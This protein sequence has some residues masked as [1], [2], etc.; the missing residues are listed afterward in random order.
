MTCGIPN[1]IEMVWFLNGQISKEKSWR[2][3][4]LV[5]KSKS[6]YPSGILQWE[7]DYENHIE[8]SY[9][10]NSQLK[11]VIKNSRNFD[12]PIHFKMNGNGNYRYGHN[13]SQEHY[14]QNGT[15][16]EK[17]EFKDGKIMLHSCWDEKGHN[18]KC[19]W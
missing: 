8:K 15:L 2:Y 17:I 1:G 7:I 6:Y 5:G 18:I 3:G 19:K 4:Y 11:S 10:D 16:K 9:F 12:F 14:Y 13:E